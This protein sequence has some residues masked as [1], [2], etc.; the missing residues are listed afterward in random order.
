MRDADGWFYLV[1]RI[2]DMIVVSGYKVWP[3]D[4]EDVLYRHPAVLE[5]G[6]VGVPDAYRGETVRAYVALRAGA[7]ASDEELIAHCRERLAVYKAPREVVFVEEI[8]KTL[9]GKALRREL[10]E[11]SR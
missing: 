8:P 11:R 6:V 3:R 10:R 1:D 7:E 4:V 5:A 9:T 2:K